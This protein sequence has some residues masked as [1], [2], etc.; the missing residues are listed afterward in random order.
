MARIRGRR[1]A[2]G[3]TKSNGTEEDAEGEAEYTHLSG[4]APSSDATISTNRVAATRYQ[5]FNFIPG[6]ELSRELLLRP[7]PLLKLWIAPGV[8]GSRTM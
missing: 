1:V 2:R 5:A 7:D 8:G 4:V 3:A 6:S